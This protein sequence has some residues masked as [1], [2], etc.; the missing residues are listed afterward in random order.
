MKSEQIQT[1]ALVAVAMLLGGGAT[2]FFLGKSER[3]VTTLAAV[4]PPQ[5]QPAPAPV[6][7]K[8]PVAQFSMQFDSELDVAVAAAKAA[9]AAGTF[10]ALATT[11]DEFARAL[12]RVN[13]RLH[14]F[15]ARYEEPP[16]PEDTAFA[17]YSAELKQL[18]TD[19]ANL[20]SD[21]SLM[22]EVEDGKPQALAHHQALMAGGALELDEAV[23]AKIE[24]IIAAANAKALPEGL[25]DREMTPE[26]EAEFDK[27]FD[28]LTADIEAQ[29]RPLLTPAQIKRL[30][31]LGAEQVLFGLSGE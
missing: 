21:E 7:E 26:E 22:S 25:G 19:L 9:R 13:F 6:P 10:K 12:G 16:A 1:A 17:K 11:S 5:V 29:I 18:T 31:E 2:Y 14:D 28:A 20:L 27:K 15:G 23:T 30:D 4:A 8:S 3:Q 24:A